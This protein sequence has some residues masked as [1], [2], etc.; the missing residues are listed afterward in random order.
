LHDHAAGAGFG[1]GQAQPDAVEGFVAAD[2]DAGPRFVAGLVEDA[3]EPAVDGLVFVVVDG[4]VRVQVKAAFAVAA[5]HGNE[6][7]HGHR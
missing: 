3:A 1:G 7:A 2:R 6:S 4:D 5:L